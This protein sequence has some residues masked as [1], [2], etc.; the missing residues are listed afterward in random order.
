MMTQKVN[1]ESYSGVTIVVGLLLTIS[2]RSCMTGTTL[3]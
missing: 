2:N 1:I 3:K